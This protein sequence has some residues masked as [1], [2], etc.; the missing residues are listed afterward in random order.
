LGGHEPTVSKTDIM[1]LITM[2]SLKELHDTED[3]DYHLMT[4]ISEYGIVETCGDDN[5]GRK[6]IICSAC[7][8]PHEDL[9]KNS[10]F[11]TVDK[12]YDCLLK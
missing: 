4:K 10:E 11:K 9:I 7:R 3:V 1:C 8:L 12:F 5:F 6:I 2:F